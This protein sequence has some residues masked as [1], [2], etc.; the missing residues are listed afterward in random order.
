MRTDPKV[1]SQ[2]LPVFELK[3]TVLCIKQLSV[4]YG[5]K[6]LKIKL[7]ATSLYD[8]MTNLNSDKHYMKRNA[9]LFLQQADD[10]VT[11]DNKIIHS[12]L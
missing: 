2:F 6:F 12:E 3:S 1:I 5:M 7:F 10:L 4:L 11:Q 8:G 9:T